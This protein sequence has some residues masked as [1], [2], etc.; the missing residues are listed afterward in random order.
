[1]TNIS[2]AF[3]CSGDAYAELVEGLRTELGC[4]D[5]GAIAA[6]ILDSEKAE[7]HW[8]ARV[9]E[10]YLGQHLPYDCGDEEAAGDLSRMAILSF[11]AGRWHA[12]VCIVD[13][14]GCAAD[15][16]WLH[17]FDGRQDAEEAFDRAR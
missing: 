2:A 4:A 1:M 6:R 10:R 17:T 5:V 12:G 7:F 3:G 16:L 15:L 9:K 13:G 11:L 8:E 14:D